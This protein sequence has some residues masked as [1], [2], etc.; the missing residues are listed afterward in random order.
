[1]NAQRCDLPRNQAD[2]DTARWGDQRIVPEERQALPGFGVNA[3]WISPFCQ[4]LLCP[5]QA[6]I[7]LAIRIAKV[8]V[9]T[10]QPWWQERLGTL[11]Q[12]LMQE[13]YQRL[14]VEGQREGPPHVGG[15]R[16]GV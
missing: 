8:R 5:G 1:M 15:G 9:V 7:I 3:L 12:S 13:V 2:L 4:Q 14:G 10:E 11:A 6:R 16:A